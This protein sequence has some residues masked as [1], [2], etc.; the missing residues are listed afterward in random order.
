MFWNILFIV[1]NVNICIS[2]DRLYPRYGASTSHLPT[3]TKQSNDNFDEQRK[4]PQR[5]NRFSWPNQLPTNQTTNKQRTSS[6]SDAKPGFRR[7]I[8]P[9]DAKVFE[10]ATQIVMYVWELKW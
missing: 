2:T 1:V 3:R 7:V 5:N 9:E 6:D 8:N 4:E 10:R